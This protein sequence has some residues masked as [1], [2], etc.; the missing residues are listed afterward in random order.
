MPVA[1]ARER[2]LFR[3]KREGLATVGYDVLDSPVGPLWVAIGP[4]GVASIHFGRECSPAAQPASW[5]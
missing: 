2:L 3:A 5:I 1:E 4:D